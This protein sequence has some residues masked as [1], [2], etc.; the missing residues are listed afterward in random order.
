MIT[1]VIA[2]RQTL[3]PL[4]AGGMLLGVLV[5]CVTLGALVGWALGS[6]GIGFAIG[7]VIGIPV[8]IFTVY[9][10]YRGAF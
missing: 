4:N 8:A 2:E 7:A 5:V 1:A 3:D 10:T 9:R 6:L